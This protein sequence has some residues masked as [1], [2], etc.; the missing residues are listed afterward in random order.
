MKKKILT[1]IALCALC[2]TSLLASSQSEDFNFGWRFSLNAAEDSFKYKLDDKAWDDV[3][4]PHDWSIEMGY[5]EKNTAGSNGFLPGGIGWYRKSFTLPETTKGKKVFIHFEG[6]YSTSKVWINGAELGMYPSGY[7]GFEYDLTPHLKFGG[8]ENIVCVRADRSQYADARW[9]V[10]GGIYRNVHLITRNDIYIPTDGVFITTPKVSMKEAEVCVDIELQKSLKSKEAKVEVKHDII[11]GEKLT[12][13]ATQSALLKD[14]LHCIK[15]TFKIDNPMLWSTEQPSMY[16]LRSTITM[17]GK[18]VDIRETKFGVRDIKFDAANGFFVNGKFTKLKGVNIHHDLGCVGVAAYDKVL[19]RRLLSLKEMGCNAIRTAHNPHS[20]SLLEMCDT[21]GLMV[22][23]EMFDEWKVSKNKWIDSR[24]GEQASKEISKGY[25]AYFNEWGERDLKSFVRRDRNHPSVILWSIGNELEWT[26]GYYWRACAENKKGVNGLVH[27]G[28]PE[29][30][31]EQILA[32]FNE[33]CNG[34][35]E[36]SETAGQLVKWTKDIDTT[37]MVTLGANLPSVSRLSGLM[38]ALDVVGYNYKNTYY[39]ID[40]KRYPDQPIIGSENVGQYYEWR[41]VMDKP[42]I[43]GIFVWVGISYIGESGPWPGKGSDSSFFD[44]ACFKNSRGHFFET[45]WRDTPKTHIVTTP[46]AESEFRRNDD[47]TYRCEF[48]D[49]KRKTDFRGW[50]WFLTYD[51]W[52]YAEGEKI[53][54]QAYSN[55]PQVELLLNGK[56]LGT[57]NRSEFAKENIMLWEVPYTA[58]ELVAIGKV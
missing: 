50:D 46:T 2:T 18:V 20:S 5:S 30:Q 35:D 23:N 14:E 41:D 31:N 3:R 7:L 21:M 51:K 56:S 57:K 25:V 19:Y 49:E 11:E 17:D 10:G 48:K 1:L 24:H 39:E 28:G 8:K 58:G 47:G 43:P 37:R 53:M 52:R 27:L 9:Y 36:L 32:R 13:V 40:H 44:F 16:T 42:Y 55:A 22:M 54:V 45:L 29:T 38:G 6:V 15:S 4:I 26:Y 34:H 33:Y 12:T